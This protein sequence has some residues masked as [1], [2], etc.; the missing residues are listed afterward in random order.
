[1]GDAAD[2][3]DSADD[4]RAA[5]ADG[6]AWQRVPAASGETVP[7]R[8]SDLK[9]MRRRIDTLEREVAAL[10]GELTSSRER[11][12]RVVDR[13]ETLLDRRGREAWGETVPRSGGTA[14][15]T[16]RAVATDGGDSVGV[17]TAVRPDRASEKRRRER[18]RAVRDGSG[19]LGR[20]LTAVAA[21]V[22]RG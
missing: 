7:V 9:A 5:T 17:E 3:T 12:Q 14:T 16:E 20:L 15:A 18:E 19:V 11:R 1:M 10:E 21:A 2:H 22:S 6:T 8:W 4:D 13:Y